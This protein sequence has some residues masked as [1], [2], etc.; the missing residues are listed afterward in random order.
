MFDVPNPPK[1]LSL[2]RPANR[3][4]RERPSCAPRYERPLDYTYSK[5]TGQSERSSHRLTPASTPASV[6]HQ[7][8]KRSTKSCTKVLVIKS[9]NVSP[10]MSKD[11]VVPDA[12]LR[13]FQVLQSHDSILKQTIY[14]LQILFEDQIDPDSV[15]SSFPVQYHD[16]ILEC[17]LSDVPTTMSEDQ[18]DP[19]FEFSLLPEPQ[20]QDSI[21]DSECKSSNLPPTM[22]EDQ[23]DLGSGFSDVFVNE[24]Q[25]SKTVIE[26]KNAIRSLR[27]KLALERQRSSNLH[28]NPNKFLNTD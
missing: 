3:L 27:I 24:V 6:D 11:Q 21:P 22:S 7:Y 4:I 25:D 16:S 13:S 2:K 15:I 26:L 28:R 23:N 1:L 12:E 20:Y 14:D 18:I 9:S 19:N 17:T 8:S 10:A 5:L